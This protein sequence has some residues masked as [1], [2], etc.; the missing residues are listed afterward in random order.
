MKVTNI[1]ANINKQIMVGQIPS[2]EKQGI[3]QHT[4]TMAIINHVE[5]SHNELYLVPLYFSMFTSLLT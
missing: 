4:I 1:N 3:T 2:S 5:L